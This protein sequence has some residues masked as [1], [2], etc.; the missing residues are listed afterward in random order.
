MK[1]K[2]E[3]ILVSVIAGMTALQ[4]VTTTMMNVH[5]NGQDVPEAHVSYAKIETNKKSDLEA[6]LHD[7]KKNVEDK[8][9]TLDSAKGQVSIASKQVEI[10]ESKQGEMNQ[11]V[12]QNYQAA[13]DSIMKELQPLM[14]EINSLES[15]IK[16]A[17]TDLDVK[18]SESQR[19]SEELDQ[20]Q[21]DLSSKKEELNKLQDKLASFGEVA[22][23]KASLENAKTEKEAA[24]A[25][26]AAAKE[27]SDAANNELQAA[28]A[29]VD[30]KQTAVN[31]A[32]NAYNAAMQDVSVKESIVQEKQAIVDQYND[33]NGIENAKA[34]LEAA[35]ADLA[36][37]Q[38][39][40][41]TLQSTL[42][43]AQAEYDVAVVASQSAQ[44]N[45]DRAVSELE[46]AK[47]GLE[48]AQA[49]LEKVYADYDANKKEMEAKDKEI[50]SLNSQ[51]N[52]AQN[53]VN[54]AQSDY[55]KA[56][57]DYNSTM[58]PLDQA[59]KNLADFES[60]Y[61]TDLNRLET[62]SK[63]YF[64]SIGVGASTDRI[65]DKNSSNAA[66]AGLASYTNMG[67]KDDATSLE[68]MQA[69]IA[70][71]KECN[72]IRKKEGLSELKVSAWLMAVA[73]AN[74]NHAKTNIGHAGVYA[75][76][77]N[78]AWG[79]GE[80]NTSGS[81]YRGWYD[82]EKAEYLAG[83][84]NFSDVGHYKNI[85]EGRYTVTGFAVG[86]DGLYS[87]AFAQEFSDKVRNVQDEVQMTVSE[88][89]QSFNS[90]YDNLKSVDSQ[91][92][93]LQ[94]AL[95]NA[96]SSTTKDD[97]LLK[98]TLALLNSKKDTLSGLQNQ[99]S[100]L[101]RSKAELEKAS[102]AKKDAVDQK[103]NR[104]FDAQNVVDQ[105][106]SAKAD[107]EKALNDT[108]NVVHEKEEAKK[109]AEAKLKDAKNS[110]S[111]IQTK[112]DTFTNNIENWD[113][114]KEE[115][116]K[117]LDQANK[118][119][120]FAK[121]NVSK[122][123]AT[124]EDLNAELDAL[125]AAQNEAQAK[126]EENNRVLD[127]SQ[128]DFDQKNRVFEAAQKK[129]S[130]YEDT[131]KG[132]ESVK[133]EMETLGTRIDE[134]T[135]SKADSEKKIAE[136]KTSISEWNDSLTE[137][138]ASA[139]PYEQMKNVLNDVMSKGTKADLSNIQDVS[140]RALLAQLSANV[141]ELQEIN[142]ALSLAKDNY[143]KKH[144]AYVDAKQ[145][146][147]DAEKDYNETMQALNDYLKEPTTVKIKD[148]TATTSSSVNTGV[149]TN[150]FVP[151][152][153]SMLAALGVIGVLN[154]KRKED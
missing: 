151:M 140:M 89:E 49:A 123:S 55:D 81:P 14:D 79:Y 134:L 33:E 129:V 10:I 138:K 3:K 39:T 64:D 116:N 91:H 75:T 66:K 8:T 108:L 107:A 131:V 21:R 32:A 57:N 71:L 152:M 65:F 18:I 143:A 51:I 150:A 128:A 126:A 83:N 56:L 114:N 86:T 87:T 12:Q 153:T 90:Y 119:L 41:S 113:T 22:D 74:A 28:S 121:E 35:Q 67:Q 50:T 76:G 130:D 11:L 142:A 82:E 84:N 102:S 149:E 23:L 17:K 122:T 133:K 4:G 97:T 80:A 135:K 30:L 46:S 45:Y 42:T 53:E 106:S 125:K 68:N 72:E 29:D 148:D 62:G 111:S 34:E 52:T 94:D 98:Q 38:N 132:V 137:N 100:T 127:T 26:F 78:L 44:A 25:T 16:E 20:A 104:V 5:A 36:V 109:Q 61:A 117:A 27:N 99:L 139:L 144:N 145:D 115:A 48:S 93:A 141:D 118:D 9:L 59:K 43:Q 15:Q 1:K 101:N 70:Y 96:S 124:L 112:I 147:M 110:V 31:E 73:Q 60:K 54:Q 19:A 146:L 95:K 105:K 7:T 103:Q 6:K 37:A 47:S 136:L 58:S 154:K 63:G 69:S 85:V 92:K 77:E 13:Y 120:V 2:N 24:E 88:F 40:A